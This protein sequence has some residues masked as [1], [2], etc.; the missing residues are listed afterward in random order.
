[1]KR[2]E[3]A[4]AALSWEVMRYSEAE[5]GERSLDVRR[6]ASVRAYE[7]RGTSRGSAYN[8]ERRTIFS[9]ALAARCLIVVLD[10]CE[11]ILSLML[12]SLSPTAKPI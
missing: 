12:L 7:A 8:K 6:E 3:G 5:G 11:G 9:A 1:M 4:E 10:N 2:V